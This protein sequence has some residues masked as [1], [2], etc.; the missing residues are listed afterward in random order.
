M[1][2]LKRSLLSL[3]LAATLGVTA[4]ANAAIAGFSK[5]WTFKHGSVASEIAAFD[6]L[7]NT[8][9]VAG[10][11]GVDVLNIQTGALVQSLNTTA[12]GL[13]NSV[14]IHNGIA[15]MA[16]ENSADRT[17][18]GQVVLFDTL[19][20]SLAAG[21]STFAVGA[22][23]DMLTF[24]PDGGKI[25]VANEGTPKTYGTLASTAPNGTRTFNPAVND[26]VGSVSIIDMA[27]RSVVGTATF[28][29]VSIVGNN[30]RQ[31]T[32]MDFEPEYI[33][34]A[35]DGKRAFVALQEANAM[36]V[37]NLDSNTFEKVIGLG[38]KDF[39][40]PG[41]Q[42]DPWNNST[43]QFSSVNVK[44]LYMPDSMAAFEKNGTTYIVMA[45]EGDFREDD[46]DRSAA[47]NFGATAPLANLRVSNTDSSTGNLFAAGARSFSIR[48]ANGNLIYDSGDILD[49]QAHLRGIYDD[50]RSRDKGVEPEGV[51]LMEIGGRL[52][53]FIGL[54]RTTQGAV[55]IFDITDPEN[56]SFVDMIVTAGDVSPEGLKAFSKDGKYYLA[57]ANEVS[58]TTSLYSLTPVPEPETYALMLAG[59]GL[60]GWMARRRRT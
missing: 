47:S 34:V 9:W 41:N 45:N 13:V 1:P 30:V 10:V 24:T 37:L 40:Q 46:G 48:G 16:F 22:L 12:Y 27:S 54:E 33:A 3:A 11:T 59:L 23:P 44:G 49:K 32:G 39:S 6:D 2:H 21:T 19:T 15:A 50:G 17:Q 55:A 29:G 53:A 56:S 38:A 58:N 5:A 52:Y 4:H 57:I 31:N 18:S 28:G 35:P 8:L 14:A 25:L 42:I 51:D 20:R 36:A 7:T 26:P 60:V 43:V